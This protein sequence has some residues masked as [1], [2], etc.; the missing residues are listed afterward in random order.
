M[1]SKNLYFKLLRED[2][3]RRLWSIVLLL[4]V[5]FF[6]FPVLTGILLSDN[7]MSTGWI[8]DICI[9]YGADSV[10]ILMVTVF[11]A[12]LLALS[13]FRYL[14][15][16]QM[17]DFYHSQPVRREKMFAVVYS[18]GILIFAGTYLIGLLF[19]FVILAANGLDLILISANL[20][21]GYLLF[22]LEFLVF[23]SLAVVAVEL[24]GK[25]LVAVLGIGY[26]YLY[27][28]ILCA[29]IRGMMMNFFKTF[30]GSLEMGKIEIT[31]WISPVSLSVLNLNYLDRIPENSVFYN[32]A[33]LYNYQEL[34]YIKG[35]TALQVSALP[36]ST[37]LLMLVMFALFS[38]AALLLFTKRRSEAAGQS[39]AFRVSGP[40]LK[41]LTVFPAA[42]GFGIV[43]YNITGSQ[44]RGAWF[45]FGAF[46]G[47]ALLLCGMEILICSDIKAALCR[48][49]ELLFGIAL[50]LLFC[51]SFYRDW[52][53]FDKYLPEKEELES[54]SIDFGLSEHYDLSSST[55]KSHY[56]YRSEQTEYK[57]IELAYPLLEYAVKSTLGDIQ[58]EPSVIEMAEVFTADGT[59]NVVLPDTGQAE[60][61]YRSSS[62]SIEVTYHK[63]NGA[64]VKRRY[65]VYI[66]DSVAESL[67]DS[68]YTDP[69]Y[70]KINY[71]LYTKQ[72]QQ[73]LSG[74]EIPGFLTETEFKNKELAAEF[75]EIYREDFQKLSLSEMINGKVV[76]EVGFLADDMVNETFYYPIYES[77]SN[78]ISWL[79][80]QGDLL[81]IN[82]G[83]V[84]N[85]YVVDSY[86]GQEYE[87]NQWENAEIIQVLCSRLSM[88]GNHNIS[89]REPRY[90]VWGVALSSVE[91]MRS[92]MERFP[93]YNSETIAKAYGSDFDFNI[94]GYIVEKMNILEMLE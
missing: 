26:L 7:G 41:L 57:N 89:F 11:A 6:V 82:T 50:S 70:K 55:L 12:V 24:T 92:L 9:L 21:Y 20:F 2:G 17:T 27:P 18:N 71:V 16:A 49:K 3:K 64:D 28:I 22:L 46:I 45:Y 79:Q 31:K 62:F 75:L 73:S 39:L 56:S 33:E 80:E 94:E 61:R 43:F 34:G 65:T 63:K 81:N 83:Q 90:Y 37:I 42:A 54:V 59:M 66:P 15:S 52:Y 58:K 87:F 91:E 78:S 14:H 10:G 53:G 35:K 47:A 19:S 84:M 29:V 67:L 32:V 30:A 68:V 88:V 25:T 38:A 13:G 77:F 48:K 4:L 86:T 5:W 1:I 76:R 36:V 72:L 40:I 85:L 8:N 23:Y 44:N 60:N 51:T 93:V 74:L 69:E